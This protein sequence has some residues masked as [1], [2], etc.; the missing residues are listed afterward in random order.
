MKNLILNPPTAVWFA[1]KDNAYGAWPSSGEIDL[2]ESKGNK[3]LVQNGVNIGSE[4]IGST[5]HFGPYP[6]LN[7][8]TTAQFTRNAKSGNG[9]NNDFHR[10]QM[11][12]TPGLQHT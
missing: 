3:D 10:Y 8:F 2:I 6:G 4:Q 5:L 7:G 1:P 11:D 12:W 9:F